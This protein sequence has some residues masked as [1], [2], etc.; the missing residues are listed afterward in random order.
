MLSSF[1]ITWKTSRDRTSSEPRLHRSDELRA[2]DVTYNEQ[3]ANN[4]EEL[5]EQDEDLG[6]VGSNTPAGAD[7]VTPSSGKRL[8]K[9]AGLRQSNRNRR[10]SLI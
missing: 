2:P 3:D 8:K 7:I 1:K 6:N 10:L 5:N 4:G 9:A